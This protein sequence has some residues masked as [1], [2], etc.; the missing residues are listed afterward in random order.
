[1]SHFAFNDS[2]F[3]LDNRYQNSQFLKRPVW[4]RDQQEE[5][6]C[7]WQDLTTSLEQVTVMVSVKEAVPGSERRSES[8]N[9]SKKGHVDATKRS[10]APQRRLPSKM[11]LTRGQV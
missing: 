9:L 1:M 6:P 2:N 3:F 8:A 7:L 4:E 5:D 10:N 11:D